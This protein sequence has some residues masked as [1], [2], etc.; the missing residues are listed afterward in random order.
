MKY[1]LKV[2]KLINGMQ[3][4]EKLTASAIKN[5][6]KSDFVNY[7]F[8]LNST[9]RYE[10][11]ILLINHLNQNFI[12]TTEKIFQN[13]KK[14][15]EEFDI[16]KQFQTEN[17][18]HKLNFTTEITNLKDPRF[19]KLYIN[20]DQDQNQTQTLNNYTNMKIDE[21]IAEFEDFEIK[22]SIILE[23]GKIAKFISFQKGCYPGQEL[24][25]RVFAQ[26]TVRKTVAKI[27]INHT[28]NLIKI[29]DEAQDYYLAKICKFFY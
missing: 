25:H 19:E 13:L 27:P 23:Y 12:A 3:I 11:D 26:G 16:R 20:F 14:H 8:F 28:E 9:G 5:E 1:D 17:T 2:Y 6:I 15:I 4:L 22:K 18:E 7:L 24:M 10:A 21:E 29:L